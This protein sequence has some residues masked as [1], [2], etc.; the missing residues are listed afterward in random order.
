MELDKILKALNEEAE[1]IDHAI[2][3]LQHLATGR[4]KRRGRPPLWLNA[5]RELEKSGLKSKPRKRGRP[6]KG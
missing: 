5:A 2:V 3:T 6:R 1:A 4:G